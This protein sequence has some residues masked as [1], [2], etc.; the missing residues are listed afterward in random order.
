MKPDEHD[1][2][3]S[4]GYGL[5]APLLACAYGVFALCCKRRTKLGLPMNDEDAIW[6]SIPVFGLALFFHARYFSY[7]RRH[8]W[9]R[10]GLMML[11]ILI[12]VA[13]LLGV[14]VP[15]MRRFV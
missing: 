8:L 15:G 6:F 7:Y 14:L 5:F 13:G 2:G 1:N 3:K 11:A 4:T 9:L 12:M 10:W